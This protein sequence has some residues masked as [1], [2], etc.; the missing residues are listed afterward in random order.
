MHAAVS[1]RRRV[2]VRTFATEAAKHL[3]PEARR[4]YYSIHVEDLLLEE[5]LFHVHHYNILQYTLLG[6][7]STGTCSY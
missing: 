5:F 6:V 1:R 4:T 2:V 3:K 7:L